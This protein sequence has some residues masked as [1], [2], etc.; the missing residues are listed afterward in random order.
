MQ[1]QAS[2]PQKRQ[3]ILCIDLSNN[4][5]LH[6]T[7]PNK[8]MADILKTE[9]LLYWG[10]LTNEAG[11][12]V[13]RIKDKE[14]NLKE[15]IKY[16]T[17]IFT[18]FDPKNKRN[19]KVKKSFLI[20][21]AAIDNIIAALKPHHVFDSFGFNLPPIKK[22]SGNFTKLNVYQEWHFDLK[23]T[24]WLNVETYKPLSGYKPPPELAA[25]LDYNINT[26]LQ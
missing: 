7:V 1:V 22:V 4:P 3:C 20:Y 18:E 10:D 12:K 5:H 21:A 16:S 15:V 24:D 13:L 19:P 6:I 2:V 14:R 26:Y 11:Q 17:K 9:W 23:K 8:K 25:L